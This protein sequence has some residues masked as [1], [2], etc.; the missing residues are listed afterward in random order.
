MPGIRLRRY[1]ALD[2]A[3]LW[4]QLH[5]RVFLREN[6][7]K[8]AWRLAD[9]ERGFLQKPWWRPARMW[10][11]ERVGSDSLES[12]PGRAV[13]E[14]SNPEVAVGSVV[15]GESGRPPNVRQ[16]VQWLAVL[17]EWRGRGIGRALM[18]ALERSCAT[19]G[20]RTLELETSADWES[21]VR[22][23]HRL[24]YQRQA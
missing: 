13:V 2:D 15:W 24:G 1:Q 5:N 11:A 14:P 6:A 4:I 3:E 9:F 17:P 16:T 20:F 8:R 7:Q 10:F 23:Y 19:A 18:E 12:G 22:L 21:A